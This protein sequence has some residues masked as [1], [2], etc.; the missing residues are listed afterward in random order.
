M[1]LSSSHHSTIHHHLVLLLLLV[2]LPSRKKYWQP[3]VP[4]GKRFG[5]RP[6]VLEEA[7][8][9]VGVL[10]L[11]LFDSAAVMAS[12]APAAAERNKMVPTTQTV[13]GHDRGDN[14]EDDDRSPASF[15]GSDMSGANTS[16]LPHSLKDARPR[17]RP[18]R[19]S[20]VRSLRSQPLRCS[21]SSIISP[22][23]PPPR[24]LGDLDDAC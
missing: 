3:W 7:A 19:Y 16:V 1:H 8:A 24:S 12:A 15:C 22:L 18:P 5:S 9:G 10:L 17:P 6:L 11:P 21:N 14:H 13:A 4:R 2:L 20:T 23:S